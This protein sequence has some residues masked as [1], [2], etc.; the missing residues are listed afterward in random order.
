MR[1]FIY[2]LLSTGKIVQ[3]IGTIK[4]KWILLVLVVNKGSATEINGIA[5]MLLL[6]DGNACCLSIGCMKS[7]LT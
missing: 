5:R 3:A 6:S 2:L 1:L 4:A 7:N